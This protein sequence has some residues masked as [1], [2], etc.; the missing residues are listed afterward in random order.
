MSAPIELELEQAIASLLES[1]GE[2]LGV[3]VY[4]GVDERDIAESC[5]VVNAQ[6]FEPHSTGA[7]SISGLVEVEISVLTNFGTEN[8]PRQT[9]LERAARVRDELMD[10]EIISKLA[11]HLGGVTV[12][13][14]I[15]LKGRQCSVEDGFWKHRTTIVVPCHD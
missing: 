10:D 4:F 2:S 6:S 3:K 5:I 8:T 13:G 15:M 11:A 7:L 1:V 9:H 12:Y 14:D